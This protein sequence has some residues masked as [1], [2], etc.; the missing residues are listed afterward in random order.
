M[1]RSKKRIL[2]KRKTRRKQKGG[3]MSLAYVINLDERKD[4]WEQVS[5]A[6][7]DLPFNI[8]RFPAIKNNMGILGCG[9]SHINIIKKAKEQNLKYVIVMED[10]VKPVENFKDLWPSVKKYLETHM[11]KWEIFL[12]QNSY[13]ALFSSDTSTI[14]P[15]CKLNE[16]IKLYY[17]NES[18]ATQFVI[19]N[20]SIYDKY[21]EL[22]QYLNENV[23]VPEKHAIDRWSSYNKMKIVTCIP[24]IALQ[25]ISYSDI[26]KMK[27]NY[28]ASFENTAKIISSVE[29]N[30]QCDTNGGYKR[31]TRRK[32]KGGDNSNVTVVSAYYPMKSKYSIDNYK[33]WIQNLYGNIGFNLVFFT[34][35]EYT[36][37]IEEVRKNFKDK[38]KII[39]LEFED[40]E[41]LKK[42]PMSFWEDQ[43]KKD[44]ED[45]HTPDMYILWYEKKEFL[46]K[47][48]D[49]NPFNTDYFVWT[50]AGICRD[51]NWIPFLKDYPSIDKIPNDKIVIN[52]LED[53]SD[54]NI[55][56]DFQYVLTNVGAGILAG[57]KD[58]WNKYYSLYDEIF[59]MYIND[60][61]FIGK[62]QN[63][64]TSMVIKD[65]DL[66]NLI[67]AK[68]VHTD[69][70]QYGIW[71]SLLFYLAGL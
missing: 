48:I 59:N 30:I 4:R 70:Y 65:G 32:Q 13:Y 66:F 67:Q 64:M 10:D 41:A 40:F 53:F 26:V 24:F 71:S 3:N 54:K 35:K 8:Q 2:K 58:T 11:D 50:D 55:N 62:E 51:K 49:M 47:A 45:Y 7:K 27:V 56:Y 38:T 42:Y 31:K 25:Q 17:T 18:T 34:N 69:E 68:D 52:L 63:I 60:G 1:S 33:E 36:P 15:L 19:Y 57:K 46:K 16:N 61:R 5:N 43:K 20:S 44:H 23:Y 29:N 21:L 22:E 14:Q 6:L 28:D 9:L 12:G 39:T 37:F